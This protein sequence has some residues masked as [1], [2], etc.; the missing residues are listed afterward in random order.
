MNLTT[1]PRIENCTF[2]PATTDGTGAAHLREAIKE[3]DRIRR[4]HN[5]VGGV[6]LYLGHDGDNA[7]EFWDIDAKPL[8]KASS[9]YSLLK[10]VQKCE[11]EWKT[12]KWTKNLPPLLE[13]ACNHWE[14]HQSHLQP[15]MFNTAGF[16]AAVREANNLVVTSEDV[17]A[18]LE[19]RAD[20]VRLSGGCH[21]L[22]LPR[23]MMKYEPV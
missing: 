8:A 12:G 23:G 4:E 14:K 7:C 9:G 2:S 22:V 6:Y 10:A 1:E 11:Q 16:Q 20:I 19:K 5:G 17:V 15:K 21:W 3:A 13:E 18:V